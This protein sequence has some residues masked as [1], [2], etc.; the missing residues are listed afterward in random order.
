MEVAYQRVEIEQ[1]DISD[2]GSDNEREGGGDGG[3][4]SNPS[5]DNFDDEE[6]FERVYGL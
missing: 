4:D 1:K 2:E 6:I 5:E 3:S